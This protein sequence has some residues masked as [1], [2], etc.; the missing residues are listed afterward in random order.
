[1]QTL[2]INKL[3]E[4]DDRKFK[5]KVIVN[6]HGA[7]IMLLCLRAGQVVPEH[8]TQGT[9]TVQAIT[10]H[11]TFYD[12]A[13]PCE[14]FAGTLV[15]LEAGRP[16]RVEAHQDSVLLVT[17][18]GTQSAMPD[19]STP[20]KDQELDLRETPRPQRHPLAFAA[21]DS[22]AVGEAFTLVNDHD[23][24]PLR[25]QIERMRE[26]EMGW[27]YIERGT[28][29]FRIRISRIA[30]PAGNV[31]AVTTGTPDSPVRIG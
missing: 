3:V 28:E 13:E 20:A 11:A 18:T 23:P 12:G 25:M 4:F 16:H 24:Q 26:G 10:G 9:V 21:F 8:S 22:L 31:G 29:T 27:E 14:M 6:E 17:V 5:P 30:P 15:R 19:S 2:N 7:R 1:M